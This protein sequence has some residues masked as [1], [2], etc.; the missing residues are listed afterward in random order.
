MSAADVT[1]TI[2]PKAQLE[3]G[4]EELELEIERTGRKKLL[5]FAEL[6]EKW[7]R[8]YNLT[9]IRGTEQ[10]VTGHLLDC[11][12][13]VRHIEGADALD[14]G[15]GAGFPGIPLAIARPGM[16]VTLLDSN[17]KKVAFLREAVSEL[18]LD[19]ATVICERVESWQPQEKFDLITSRALADLGETIRMSRHLL[20]HG[21]VFA[22]MKGVLPKEEME[23]LPQGYRVREALPIAVPGL[24]AER[25]LILMERA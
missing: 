22:A 11:L 1:R 12:A 24:E 21:G 2:D 14:V 5:D 20:A 19:N 3:R 16:R 13:I 6:L 9:G 10:I 17:Q 25:H 7:N 4:L 23:R 18:M 15:S 8:V